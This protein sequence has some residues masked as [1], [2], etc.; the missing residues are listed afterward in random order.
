M[1]QAAKKTL[2]FDSVD[3]G[4][5]FFQNIVDFPQTIE[6][7]ISE[8]TTLVCIYVVFALLQI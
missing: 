6:H 8:N 3:G 5:R 7:Y 1:K 4:Y 2:F